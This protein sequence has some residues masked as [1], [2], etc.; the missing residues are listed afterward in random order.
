MTRL[1]IVTVALLLAFGCTPEPVESDGGNATAIQPVQPQV[2]QPQVVQP[3]MVEKI[4]LETVQ[5]IPEPTPAPE[6]A[7]PLMVYTTWT[8]KKYHR[9][10]CR[11]IKNSETY[12]S[13]IAVA[14]GDGYDACKVCNPPS[15]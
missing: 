8:G 7:A 11:T 14:I 5:P 2:V 4:T 15:R 10:T 1:A 3:A 6:P 13:T 9:Y 12:E